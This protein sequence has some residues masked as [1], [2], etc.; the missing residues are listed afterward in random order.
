MISMISGTDIGLPDISIALVGHASAHLPHMVQRVAS[1]VIP[2]VV[3]LMAFSG[4]AATQV[5]HLMH[6]AGE[7]IF[8]GLPE[9]L[10]GLWHQAQ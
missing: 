1:V 3:N 4:H 2:R 9:I 7:Y 5:P 8:S 10:S 6:F